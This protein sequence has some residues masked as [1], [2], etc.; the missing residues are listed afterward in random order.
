MSKSQI[1]VID[2][3]SF[4]RHVIKNILD[5]HKD[6]M[7][8]QIMDNAANALNMIFNAEFLPDLILCDVIMPEL[9]GIEFITRL[10]KESKWADIPIVLMTGKE[11]LN[12]DISLKENGINYFIMKPFDEDVVISTI[13]KGLKNHV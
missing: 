9:D 13:M 1:L 8:Y 11:E 7:E 4:M 6:M 10:K 5:K 3:S 2:D 12:R